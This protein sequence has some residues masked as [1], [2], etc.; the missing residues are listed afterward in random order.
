MRFAVSAGWVFF[1]LMSV[2]NGVYAQNSITAL[3]VSDVG[4]NTSVIKVELAQPLA[5]LPAGAGFT[6][7]NPPRIV[8]DFLDTAN[9]LGKSTQDFIDAGVRSASI[10]Q[11][12]E[13]TRLIVYLNQMFPNNIRIEGRSLLIAVQVNAVKADAGGNATRNAEAKQGAQ[14]LPAKAVKE[15]NKSAEIEAQVKE[16]ATP[17]QPSILMPASESIGTLMREADAMMK[18]GKSADAYNLLE[19]KEGDY[20]GDV[21]FDYL[22]GIAALDSGRPDRATIA[23][24]RILIVN[25][26]FSGARL[27]LAR[28][29]FV[30]GSDDIA[31]NEFETVLTQSP[32]EQVK[33]VVQKY[34]EVIEERRKAR[35]QQVNAYLEGS[36]GN[37]SNITAATPD[38]T[39][40]VLGA[41]SIPGAIA[42]GSAVHYSAM[43]SG[44]STGVDL[45]RLVSE[46]NGIKLFAG[47]D[48][49]QRTYARVAAMNNLN[50]DL[51]A[52]FSMAK[53]D[54]NYRLSGTFGQFR[55][56]GFGTNGNRD[57]AGLGAEWKRSFGARDQMIWSANYSQPR[58]QMSP[59]QDTNQTL[60]SAS[61]LHI[62]EGKFIP[63]IFANLNRSKDKALQ[64]LSVGG[65]NVDRT[66]TGVLAHLQFT[67][68]DNTEFFMTAGWTVRHDDS[69]GARSS[70][71]VDFYARDV[72]R[73]VS[74]GVIARP[75]TKWTI[76][77]TV[78]LTNNDSNLSLY[79]YK[80]TDGSV[81]V[82]RDF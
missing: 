41:F 39:G 15:V 30:M 63:L 44:L 77:G 21:G 36:V 16:P 35:I 50:L 25:P 26:N 60:L 27:D 18:S 38:F 61:W 46:Q 40:G 59:G 68:L 19:P 14:K 1:G 58:N 53:G 6:L 79:Q 66:G 75:W 5:D 76:K 20:S 81:S 55:Q 24:E 47:A 57:T 37:D 67:P 42:T 73:N 64:P 54:D 65:T 28:A 22:L 8:L 10:S 4:N 23:F 17:L 9:G 71:L 29:F 34:L 7:S 74:T 11:A 49:R 32:P 2:A 12:G 33:A 82:R 62:F 43:Y 70:G 48:V 72:T 45:T 3:N 13:S 52:G 80:R 56:R 51:R 78:A 31:K 69:P